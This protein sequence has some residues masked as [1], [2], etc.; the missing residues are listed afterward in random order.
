MTYSLFTD[1][2]NYYLGDIVDAGSTTVDTFNLFKNL[3]LFST[4]GS[5]EIAINPVQSHL[6][7]MSTITTGKPLMYMMAHPE[8]TTMQSY[9][10]RV[11]AR[12]GSSD[13]LKTFTS[14]GCHTVENTSASATYLNTSISLANS[15]ISNV[16]AY[17]SNTGGIIDTKNTN[18][19][20]FHYVLDNESIGCIYYSDSVTP[21]IVNAPAM[22]K[23]QYEF[24]YSG[25]LEDAQSQHGQFAT[26]KSQLVNLR[27]T[28]LGAHMNGF[29]LTDQLAPMNT[30]VGV[31][32]G[33]VSTEDGA[34]DLVTPNI[35]I[36]N[37]YSPA[38]ASEMYSVTDFRVHFGTGQGNYAGKLPNLRIGTGIFQL[39]KPVYIEENTTKSKVW[40]P[41]ALISRR[42]LLLRVCSTALNAT[43]IT[44]LNTTTT[45]PITYFYPGYCPSV[46]V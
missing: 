35:E 22:Y 16:F 4:L 2:S 39:G 18:P 43:N 27:A 19:R 21:A 44:A 26:K 42:F 6:Q 28:N 24:F 31:L 14:V 34:I 37:V 11:R 5:L 45:P 17:T 38:A 33:T 30:S 25:Y 40:L 36:P 9:A 3:A 1:G 20:Y 23:Y 46:R 15:V 29:G 8:D 12:A 7:Q 41:V 32:V 13:G 10:G